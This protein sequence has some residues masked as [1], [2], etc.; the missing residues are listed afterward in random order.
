MATND[1]VAAG[2]DGYR[3]FQEATQSPKKSMTGSTMKSDRVAYSDSGR[4]LKD[5]LVEYIK[6]KKKIAPKIEGR[7]I[8]VQ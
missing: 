4:W 1:F 6:E 8:E 3:S 2:G 5:V 7:I